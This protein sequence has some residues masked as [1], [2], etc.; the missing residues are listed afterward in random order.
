MSKE[1]TEI[2]VAQLGDFIGAFIT[3]WE[4]NDGKRV[5]KVTGF[6]V[7]RHTITYEYMTPSKGNG[8]PVGVSVRAQCDLSQTIMVFHTIEEAQE[9]IEKG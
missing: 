2:K 7:G 9:N 1:P 4:S 8:Q 3:V 5:A 6:D